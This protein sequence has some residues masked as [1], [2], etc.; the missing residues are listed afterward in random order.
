MRRREVVTL[1]GSMAAGGVLT[2][3]LGKQTRNEHPL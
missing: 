2:F 1:L 3:R